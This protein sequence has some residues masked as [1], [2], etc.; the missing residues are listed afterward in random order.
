MCGMDEKVEKA[1]KSGS[2][3]LLK[4]SAGA[5]IT[6]GL[7]VGA[8]ALAFAATDPGST[9]TTPPTTAANGAPSTPGTAP[10]PAPG[11]GGPGKFGRHGFGGG[12][13]I[14]G[15]F[16]VPAPNGGYETLDNQVGQVTAVSNSSITVKSEDGFEKAYVVDDNTVVNAGRDGIANVQN[17]N[18]V[19]LVAVVANGKA[20]AVQISDETTLQQHRGTWA[21]K[22]P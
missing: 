4:A 16:T 9:T 12:P 21:P 8:G 17:G 1:A 19:R 7:A 13:G 14:H 20:S 5:A 22:R 10:A 2:N 11:P 3:R 6:A 18:T 15:E